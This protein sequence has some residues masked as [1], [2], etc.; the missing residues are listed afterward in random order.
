MAALQDAEIRGAIR[1]IQSQQRKRIVLKDGFGRGGGRLALML[2]PAKHGITAEWY[3]TQHQAGRR[4][5]AKIGVYPELS[6]AKAREE[7]ARYS[8]NIRK[9]VPVK[10]AQGGSDTLLAMLKG[11]CNSLEGQRTHDE[12]ERVLIRSKDSAAAFI[13]A[14]KKASEVTTGE[15]AEWLRVFY[16][17]GSPA[18]ADA[19]RNKIRAAFNWALGSTNDYTQQGGNGWGLSFNPAAAI[20]ADPEARKAGTRFLSRD[21]LLS[22]LSWLG[23]IGTRQAK[24]LSVIALTGQRVEEIVNLRPEHYDGTS[25]F[26]PDTK[27]GKQRG[28]KA[29]PHHIP[30]PRRCVTI[31]DEMK[32]RLFEGVRVA[33]IRELCAAFCAEK[34]VEHFT[35]RDLRRTWKTLAG[36]ARISK[37]ARD[38]LQNHSRSDI[39]SVHYDRYDY[40]EEKVEAMHRWDAWLDQASEGSLKS[41]TG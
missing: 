11:Y 19:N 29:K 32:P 21:E 12:N 13:G 16:G 31:L 38:R 40:W 28:K 34:K 10:R 26:W 1:K 20:P 35:T 18:A 2:R 4:S 23:A 33:A 36:E 41:V 27:A 39:S 8:V 15:I 25:M 24:C 7:F 14:T 22:F 9:G 37:E 17:R 6:L 5:M 30:V 3:A